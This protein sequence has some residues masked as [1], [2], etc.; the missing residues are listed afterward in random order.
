MLE[1][2]SAAVF[3]VF[4][5]LYTPGYFYRAQTL[6]G[7]GFPGVNTPEVVVLKTRVISLRLPKDHWIW[8]ERDRQSVI[9]VALDL[10]RQISDIRD[11][12]DGMN[13]EMD[14]I[15]SAINEIKNKLDNM[16]IAERPAANEQ[17]NIGLFDIDPRL[18]RAKDRLLDI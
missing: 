8:Q 3:R 7:R 16:V 12:I 4:T 5:L 13:R 15:K 1:A 14:E 10:Y 17:N 6:A 11:K 2:L 18:A 9:R